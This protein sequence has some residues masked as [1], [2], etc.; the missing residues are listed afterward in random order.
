[1]LVVLVTSNTPSSSNTHISI[2]AVSDFTVSSSCSFVFCVTGDR[3]FFTVNGVESV[4]L[5]V[6]FEH[7][8]CS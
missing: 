3:V 6:S 7:F 4:F 1:M 2:L 8:S 5:T